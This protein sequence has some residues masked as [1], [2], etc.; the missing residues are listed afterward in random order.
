MPNR[1]QNL[2][3]AI[4]PYGPNEPLFEK[5]A[6]RTPLHSRRQPV[7]G[8]GQATDADKKEDLDLFEPEK[9]EF[10][11]LKAGLQ[12]LKFSEQDAEAFYTVIGSGI[13][14]A[15]SIMTIIGVYSSVADLAKKLLGP[16]KED[17]NKK[18]DALGVMLQY[19]HHYLCR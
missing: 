6:P 3:T 11:A 19:G 16:A 10:K 8:G 2:L 1:F 14:I 17:L 9:D 15:T 12:F 4:P 18:M 7:L 5:P 13:K